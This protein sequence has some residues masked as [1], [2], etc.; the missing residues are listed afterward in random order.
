MDRFLVDP[1]RHVKLARTLFKLNRVSYVELESLTANESV[2]TMKAL[3]AKT[4]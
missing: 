2:K 1:L 4:A 3:H